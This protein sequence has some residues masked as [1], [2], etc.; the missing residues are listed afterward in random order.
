M[1]CGC[2]SDP[3]RV[4]PSSG[5]ALEGEVRSCLLQTRYGYPP[6]TLNAP[7]KHAA[8]NPKRRCGYPTSTNMM[9]GL[10]LGVTISHQRKAKSLIGDSV[11]NNGSTKGI[12]TEIEYFNDEFPTS[13]LN[14]DNSFFPYVSFSIGLC[15]NQ[16]LLYFL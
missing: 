3:L 1:F 16:I 12:G 13:V 6:D 5:S 15:T 10:K 7:P 2:P 11:S 9:P 4:F 8:G 14:R